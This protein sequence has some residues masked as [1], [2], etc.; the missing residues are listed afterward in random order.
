[1]IDLLH[2][3]SGI[4]HS[5]FTDLCERAGLTDV[6]LGGLNGTTDRPS[7]GHP[8]RSFVPADP[9]AEA[10]EKPRIE[11][12]QRARP[13]A[14]EGFSSFSS[15]MRSDLFVDAPLPP[16][17]RALQSTEPLQ[18]WS[19]IDGTAAPPQPPQ[20]PQASMQA[21][22]ASSSLMLV[23][24]SPDGVNENW[25]LDTSSLMTVNDSRLQDIDSS[26]GGGGGG[27][28]PFGGQPSSSTTVYPA[29]DEASY[30][31]V[32]RS[33]SAAITFGPPEPPQSNRRRPSRT[34]QVR[35]P[36]G[37]AVPPRVLLVDDDAVNRKLSSK[38]LEV[39]GCAIDTAVDGI[40]AVEKM[41][42]ERYDLVLM[43]CVFFFPLE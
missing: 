3:D 5:S 17:A 43:V 33:T 8:M 36:T 32:S 9:H 12:L 35:C 1:M 38:F 22:T 39:F 26:D 27:A 20:P 15:E 41:N 16:S 14:T 40:G 23:G 31:E 4:A 24:N 10:G 6:S 18:M 13:S 37:W 11:E 42:L 28:Y 7:L 30:E 2:A 29:A 19:G 21:S 34:L 25:P